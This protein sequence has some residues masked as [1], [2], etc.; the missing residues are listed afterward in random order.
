MNSFVGGV[1]GKR[2]S[3]DML[4]AAYKKTGSVHKA[5]ALIGLIGGTVHERLVRL[6]ITRNHPRW[7]EDDDDRLKREYVIFRDSGKLSTLALSMGRTTAFVSR[8]AKRLA[9][10]A[11]LAGRSKPWIV[12]WR[13]LSAEAARA[14]FDKFLRYRKG[15][16]RQIAR[17]MG[18]TSWQAFGVEMRRRFP[19][20]WD[21]SVEARETK[22]TL[23]RYGRAFEYRVRDALK[24]LGYFVLRSPQSKSPI[25]LV[26]IRRGA[27]L[28]VQCKRGGQLRVGEWN[29]LFD[30]AGSV[31]A[32]PL[33]AESAMR[34]GEDIL[35]W[36]LLE[37]K[38]GTKRAQPRGAFLPEKA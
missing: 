7:T 34:R 23:Y 13:H 16:V 30:L 19:D 21:I 32:V 12:K 14:L 10:T 20:E 36:R 3:D 1:A 24:D 38:D 18:I 25:D 22:S 15:S 37:R 35:Y 11:S 6:G 29:D 31:G 4:V 26:A 2:V 17:R 27:V 28:F 9:L 33:L 8:Q 5:G